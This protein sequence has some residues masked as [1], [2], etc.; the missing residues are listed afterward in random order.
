LGCEFNSFSSMNYKY[1][2]IAF[3]TAV[4][5]VFTYKTEGIERVLP[6]MRVW[7]PLRN[8]KAI[9]MV[10]RVHNEKPDFTTKSMI[11]CLDENPVMSHNLL[12]LTEWIHRFYYCSWGEVIQAALPVGLN[13]ISEKRLKVN[14]NNGQPLSKTEQE[15]LQ[16]I[17]K[18]ELTLKE[19]KKRWRDD[20]KSGLLNSLLKKEFL[21]I[22]EVPKQ[23]VDFKTEKHWDWNP[24]ATHK[25]E[26]VMMEYQN[27]KET[28]WIQALDYLKT[29]QLPQSHQD[30]TNHKLLSDYTLRRIEKEELIISRQL[31]TSSHTLPKNLHQPEKLNAL[32]G[33]QS[34]TFHQIRDKLDD[35]DFHSFLLYGVTGSG[36]TEVYIHALKHALN[37]GKGGMVLV[38][39]IALTPQTVRRFYQI[40]GD[41][42]AVIHSRLND[43]ERYEA[44]Q[45]LQSGKKK[46][47]IGPRSA[48]FAPVN[49]L[50]IIIVDEEH[51]GSYKQFDPAPRYHARDVAVMRAWIE[52]SV[53]VLGSATPSMTTLQ[54]VFDKKHT[55]L[56]LPSRP[57]GSMPEVHI[58]DMKQFSSAMR[59]PLTVKLYQAVENAL[60]RNE[61]V[62]L[63]YNRRGFA[64]YLQ[65]EDCGHIPQSP[66]CSVSLTYHKQKNMLLCH[67]SGYA[68]RADTLC[69]V[70]GS[71]NLHARGSG[72]QQLEAEIG[73]LFPDAR[74][75]RMDK[76]T[77]SGKYDHQ[78]IYEKFLSGNA[79][80]L[81]GTQLV[82]KGL[83]FPNVTVVGVIN[84]ETELAFPSFRS[85][86]RMF[87]LLSQVA[88]RA[89][90]AEKAG[91]VY[92]QT[93]KPEHRAIR[94]AKTHDF[95]SFSKEELTERKSLNYPP[96]RRMIRFQFKGK[97]LSLTRA[98]AE[99]FTDAIR[100]VVGEDSVLGPSPGLIE[101]M[102]GMY[103]W[104]AQIK[105]SP[106]ASAKKIEFLVNQI[107]NRYEAGKV[108]GS[109]SVR[110][111]VNVD[112]IE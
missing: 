110:I 5:R 85:G 17:E 41:R 36:K 62:I 63:L 25:M 45:G 15:I 7:V 94:Y 79:D 95:R 92:V 93:W 38:P 1:A 6:G 61:Q 58:L 46:V 4:R 111:T 104:E 35:N 2:D 67:Y 72:T 19:A 21:E 97:K 44:W 43:R 52:N 24:D 11:Q 53:V 66:D 83:D 39:E 8:E 27:K 70:C 40:F 78:K 33:E 30:L 48:V 20:R 82:S 13:F 80:I 74:L 64:S 81:I 108:K 50:G 91:N 42:I 26:S 75:L 3:P 10:V 105:I 32:S 34:D 106:K 76:D 73:S 86:E 103:Q 59:G 47:V 102:Y 65:C 29:I 14:K 60:N 88:G 107:Y 22:W 49:N 51:D 96:F 68:R 77:T 28:K 109:G 101:K 84:A 23:R 9:G 89:G 37:K 31:K 55:L 12:E 71:K 112:A 90:R 100:I 56:H 69:E 87:Q 18:D 98:V 99:S 57:G 54:G 16:D